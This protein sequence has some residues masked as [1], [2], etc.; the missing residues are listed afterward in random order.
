MLNVHVID[1]LKIPLSKV[2]KVVFIFC[3]SVGDTSTRN[4]YSVFKSFIFLLRLGLL[5]FYQALLKTTATKAII[6]LIITI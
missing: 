4:Y 2:K 6:T 1:F 5:S 3:S